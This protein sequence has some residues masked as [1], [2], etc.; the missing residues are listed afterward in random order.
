MQVRRITIALLAVS[1]LAPT[2]AAATTPAD[3][4][5][6]TPVDSTVASTVATNES[7]DQVRLY[8]E[9]N[10]P[11]L[12][13]KPGGTDSFT[14]TVQNGDDHAVDLTP[15]VFVPEMGTGRL[16]KPEWVTIEPGDVTLDPDEERT[17]D[18]TVDV[19]D[20]ADLAR[21]SG[22]IAFTDATV[23]Y[24]N[25]PPRP[26]HYA[27]FS[28][29]VYREPIVRITRGRYLDARVQVG[30]T[31]TRTITI[32]NTGDQSVPLS[33]TLDVGTRGYYPGANRHELQRSWLDIDAPSQ[34]PA[35]ESV[36]VTV[37]VDVP[38]DADPGDYDTEL[39]LGLK[40]P[41]RRDDDSYWQRIDLGLDVW[42]QPEQAFET[43]VQVDNATESMSIT[44]DASLYTRRS[45][46][47]EDP[48]FD[49]VFVAPNGTVVTPEQLERTQ[50]G[51]VTLGDGHRG[52]TDENG[53]ATRS[54]E[55][56][57]SYRVD[58]PQSGEWTVRI[59]PHNVM[60]FGY[61]ISQQTGSE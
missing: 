47:S 57:V 31:V 30:E 39:S 32:E 9:S 49:V 17:F 10:Y 35:G 61:E 37:T 54:A 34:V 4:A 53:Y 1:L 38:D 14:I 6:T 45:A 13:V 42:E 5:P 51:G 46:D 36:D 58:A 19:P 25:Q 33:P 41:H 20:G 23:S 2:A 59:M 12:E 27:G 55:Y 56:T 26:V 52:S 50:S 16:V 11:Q 21:Y 22:A 29:S 3:S 7:S 18:V 44:V 48:S 24:P 15:H 8:I 60:E 40:D 28:L 43:T